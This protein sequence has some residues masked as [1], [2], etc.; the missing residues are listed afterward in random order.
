MLSIQDA[1]RGKPRPG[2]SRKP[3]AELL[4]LLKEALAYG[5]TSVVLGQG[6][7]PAFRCQGRTDVL[8]GPPLQ[9]A[10]IDKMMRDTLDPK[11]LEELDAEGSVGV[12]LDIDGQPVRMR[13]YRY[14]GGIGVVMLPEDVAANGLETLNLPTGTQKLVKHEDGL[15]LVTGPIGSGRGTTIANLIE[16]IGAKRGC[17]IMTVERRIKMR[18]RPTKA[19]LSRRQVGRDVSDFASGLRN[20]LRADADVI[21]LSEL[22]DTETILTALGAAENGRLVVAAMN[23]GGASSTIQRIVNTFPTQQGQAIRN[24]LASCLRGILSQRLFP[25]PDGGV[26]VVAA[27]LMITT[28]AISILIREDKAAQIPKVLQSSQGEGMVSMEECL[29]RLVKKGRVPAGDAIAA[30]N[31]PTMMRSLLGQ[32]REGARAGR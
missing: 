3:H 13:L 21:A 17:H 25:S 15:V 2:A 32:S 10:Q 29:L 27:E 30:A 9:T 19:R 12:P 8:E 1:M 16:T 5:A 28:P 23:T 6:Q 14:A 11:V 24:Q 31:E 26:P 18:L 22:P 7:A 4:W 20:A